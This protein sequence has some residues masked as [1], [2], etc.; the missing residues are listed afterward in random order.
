MGIFPN[1]D[2]IIRLV[3]AVLAEQTES[4]GRMIDAILTNTMLPD[5]SRA[6]LTRMIEGA[7]VPGVQVGVK[8]GDFT[9][10]FE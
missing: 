5:I 2:A 10:A 1:R 7:A 4:G 9:Y 8:D 6:F 3:G